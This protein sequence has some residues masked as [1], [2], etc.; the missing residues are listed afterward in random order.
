MSRRFAAEAAKRTRAQARALATAQ[1]A[2]REAIDALDKPAVLRALEDLPQHIQSEHRDALEFLELL[3]H[4]LI[5]AT[6]Q[7]ATYGRLFG[8]AGPA[9]EDAR[10]EESPPPEGLPLFSNQLNTNGG[11]I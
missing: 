8:P 11:I 10:R 4:W 1:K 9:E 6:L 7:H 2:T 3:R 5:E